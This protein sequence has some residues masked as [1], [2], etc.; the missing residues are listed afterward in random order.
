MYFTDV[1]F[2]FYIV[3]LSQRNFKIELFIILFILRKLYQ[4]ADNLIIK[5]LDLQKK[6]KIKGASIISDVYSNEIII[7]FKFH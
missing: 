5:H 4:E 1:Y 3:F 2:I 6:K 7:Y